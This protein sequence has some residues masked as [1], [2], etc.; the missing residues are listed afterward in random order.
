MND[1]KSGEVG[2]EGPP[3]IKYI[4]ASV[5]AANAKQGVP[6]PEKKESTSKK[7]PPSHLPIA[8]EGRRVRRNEPCPCGSNRKAKRCHPHARILPGAIKAAQAIAANRKD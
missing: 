5:N 6:L 4:A 3:G 8:H 1:S 7:R 2:M